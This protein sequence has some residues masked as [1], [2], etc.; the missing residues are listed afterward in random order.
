MCNLKNRKK[1]INGLDIA[2][3]NSS[4]MLAQMANQRHVNGLSFM[5]DSGDDGTLC[6]NNVE[7]LCFC[8]Y[9]GTFVKKCYL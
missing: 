4:S 8:Y 9:L 2:A 5:E 1:F 3:L 7:V 6:I